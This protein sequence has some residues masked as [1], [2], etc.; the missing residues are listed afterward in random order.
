MKTIYLLRHAKSDWADAGL[1]DEERPLNE[2]GRAAAPL[3]G[4][5]MKTKRYVPD[6]VLCSTARRTVETFNLIK[7]DLA[8]AAVKFEESLYLAEPR[9]LLE[10]LRSLD[11][12]VTSVL[13][14]GHNP[15]IAQFALALSASPADAAHEAL[16]RAMREKF[17]TCALAVIRMTAKTWLAAKPGAGALKDFMRPKDLPA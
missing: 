10:R 5:Y 2:R 14:I 15:G 12:A 9:H 4:A 7:G 11:E 3:M 17:S 1:S 13:F 16:H 6:L 8:G